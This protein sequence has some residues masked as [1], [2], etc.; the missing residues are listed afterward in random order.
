METSY[1]Y[2]VL[3]SSCIVN[4]YMPEVNNIYT[5]TK[6]ESS[7]KLPIKTSG[8]HHWL[9]SVVLIVNFE[10]IP[11]FILVSI[12]WFWA[13]KF[14]LKP[15]LRNSIY[16]QAKGGHRSTVV[17]VNFEHIAPSSSVSIVDFEYVFIL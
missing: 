11:H 8:R 17:I 1:D 6:C 10:H 9:R 7:S 16:T 3:Y 14:C 4:K 15:V 12:I 2:T 13:G 5:V